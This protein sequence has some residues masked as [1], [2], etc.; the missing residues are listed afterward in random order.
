MALPLRALRLLAGFAFAALT[1]GLLGL[2]VIY[3]T[4]ADDLPDVSELQDVRLQVPL[5]VYSRDGQLI[6]EYGSQRRRPIA[7][8]DY[9]E[10]LI[11]AVL[12]AEDATFSSLKER[13]ERVRELFD[14]LPERQ[15]QQSD[16]ERV[17]A[18]LT[19]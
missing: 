13:A 14:E 5:R 18:A 12:A 17:V 3:F 15:I 1:A 7:Y 8:E 9:P 4:F 6:A 2:A 16:L 10:V 11:Q 19:D